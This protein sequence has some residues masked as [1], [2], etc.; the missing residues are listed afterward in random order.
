M[1]RVQLIGRLGRDPEGGQSGKG[2][3]RDLQPRNQR[4]L[5]RS[6]LR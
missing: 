4:I 1:N 6:R 3:Y 2:S 5:D